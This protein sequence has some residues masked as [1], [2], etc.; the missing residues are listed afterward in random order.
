M[1]LWE[2]GVEAAGGA[3]EGGSRRAGGD[4]I[5]A[6]VRSCSLVLGGD[7]QGGDGAEQALHLPQKKSSERESV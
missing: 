1:E 6:R 3:W 4:Q 7:N 5:H 2:R